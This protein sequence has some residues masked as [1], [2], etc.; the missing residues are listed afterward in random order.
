MKPYTLLVVDDHAIIRRVVVR[1]MSLVSNAVIVVEA[2]N[3]G[4]ALKILEQVQIR[5]V[6]TDYR[7]PDGTGLDVLRAARQ[8]DAEIPVLVLSGSI[9]AEDIVLKAG[10]N[11]FLAKPVDFDVLVDWLRRSIA[12]A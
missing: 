3:V 8:Q 7:L 4:E 5:A 9:E 11:H 10:A 6:V 1:A 2:P 12:P